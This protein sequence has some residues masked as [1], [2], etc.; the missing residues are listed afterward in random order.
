MKASWPIAFLVLTNVV[1]IF[2]A[3]F[4]GWS[5]S[6]I[7][8][9]YWL[10]T[11]IIGAFNIVKIL[12]SQG[13]PLKSMSG[14]MFLSLFFAVHYGMFTMVH[15]VFLGQ[16]FQEGMTVLD[17][18]NEGQFLIWTALG[19]IVSH[20]ISML[21]NFFGRGE[22]QARS[23]HNQMFAPYGRIVIMHIVVIL[24]GALAIRFGEPIWALIVMIVMKVMMDLRAHKRAHANESMAS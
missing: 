19:F 24:G 17:Y 1:P 22:Y 3:V 4:L 12:A 7:L 5:V 11:V 16:M 2:G 18:L 14:K 15:G 8:A 21:M 10:E 23:A 9:L 6:N 20:G 13:A